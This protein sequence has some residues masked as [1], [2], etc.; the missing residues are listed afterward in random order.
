MAFS[1]SV[2]IFHRSLS[3]KRRRLLLLIRRRVGLRIVGELESGEAVLEVG[4]NHAE[5][6]VN[7]FV[8]IHLLTAPVREDC[9]G[10]GGTLAD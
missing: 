2:F 3:S 5:T 6:I 4:R 7:V 1:F 9:G 10:I 8:F